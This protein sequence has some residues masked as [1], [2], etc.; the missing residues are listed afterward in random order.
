MRRQLRDGV[1]G[2]GVYDATAFLEGQPGLRDTTR[3]IEVLQSQKARLSAHLERWPT[4]DTT[5]G[6]RYIGRPFGATVGGVR[7]TPGD[8]V[9]LNES[10][11]LSWR[12][13]FEAVSDAMPPPAEAPSNQVVTG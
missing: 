9:Q 3:R 4:P 5:H 1:R 12:D 7:L 11:S 13:R 6:Y 10:Q 8:I 2:D